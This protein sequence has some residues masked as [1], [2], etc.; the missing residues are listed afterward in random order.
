M[1]AEVVQQVL[2]KAL[3]DPAFRRKL[4]EAPEEALGAFD[5][6]PEERAAF[7]GGRLGAERLEERISRTDLSA[8]IAAKTAS[9]LLKA[10]SETRRRP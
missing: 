2:E 8:A 4:S 6:T 1:S 5:L 10:P 3:S 9:P 7:R